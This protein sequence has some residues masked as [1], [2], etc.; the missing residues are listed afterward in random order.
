[1]IGVKGGNDPVMILATKL[2]IPRSRTALIT[3]CRLANRLEEGLDHALTLVTAPAGYGKTTLLSEWTKTV[4]LP[5]AWLSLDQGDNDSNRFWTHAIAAL[6]QACPD[7][8]DQPVLR[9]SSG[10]ASGLSFIAALINGLNRLTAPVVLIW[11]DFHLIEERMIVEGVSYFLEHL[12]SHIHLYIASRSMPELPLAKMRTWGRLNQ[13]ETEDLR[14]AAEEAVQF[15]ASYQELQL[16]AQETAAVME[17]TEGWAAGMR[18]AALLL[19]KSAQR[20]SNIQ[21]ISGQQR[22]YADYFMEEILSQQPN[23]LQQFLL[24]TSILERMNSELCAAVTGMANSSLLLQELEQANLFLLP[25]DEQREWYRYHHL[26]G[27]FLRAQIRMRSPE[28][29]HALHAAAGR[30]LEEN[31]F[32]YEAMDHY[33]TGSLYE[34]ALRLLK[35]LAPQMMRAHWSTLRSWFAA[36]PDSLLFGQPMLFM[37][38]MAS[39]FLSGEYEMAKRTLAWVKEKISENAASLPQQTAGMMHAGISVLEAF[40]AFFAKDFAASIRYSERYVQMHPDGDL[41]VGLGTDE[42]GYQ[43]VWDIY[44]VAGGL[45]AAEHV[46][47]EYLRVWSGTK[48]VFFVAHLHMNYARLLYE[49]N[50]LHEAEQEFR[51]ALELGKQHRHLNLT[52]MSSLW[53]ARIYSAEGRWDEADRIIRAQA[54]QVDREQYPVITGRIRWFAALLERMRADGGDAAAAWLDHCGLRYEDEIPL[55]MMD[56]YDLFACLLAERGRTEQALQVIDRLLGLAEQTGRRHDKLRL[57]VHRS[58]I[59]DKLEAEALSMDALDQALKLSQGEGYFRTFADEGRRL[60]DLLAKYVQ[61]RQSRYLGSNSGI[62][63]AYVKR[64][65]GAITPYNHGWTDA[66]QAYRSLTGQE[67]NVV[68][69]MSDGLSNKEIAARLGIAPS[70]LKTH[71]NNLYSKLQVNNRLQAIQRAKQSNQI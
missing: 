71:I 55:S 46:L 66:V 31:G 68:K 67:L 15:F 70:T 51:K 13:L 24:Q 22:D 48:N 25:L 35:K 59:L 38:K 40:N 26:F 32:A 44:A 11:D 8:D 63:L 21:R 64:L 60:S 39:F 7:F 37:M 27:Q 3:R 34:D 6:K 4:E 52:V 20:G 36:I 57:L 62:S 53:T 29:V 12:P 23:P 61:L 41:F 33:L 65:L 2:H 54:E 28:Q 43:P 49:R 56:E 47:N 14:F 16:S 58:I 19:S 30:W 69:L 45:N 42:E 1:M 9:F 50:Q 17:R 18:L 5:V 10:D